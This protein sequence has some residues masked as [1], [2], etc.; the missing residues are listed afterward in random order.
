MRGR[1]LTA[2]SRDLLWR[3]DPAR[4]G[5]ALG[6]WAFDAQPRGC[7]RPLHIIEARSSGGNPEIRNIIV[8]ELDLVII[9]FANDPRFSF[10]EIREGQGFS[11]DLLAAVACA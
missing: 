2:A 3:P 8:P 5:M 4:G 9:L 10:G 6:Q 1:L 11:H 7:T